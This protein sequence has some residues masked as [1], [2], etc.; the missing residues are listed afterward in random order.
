MYNVTFLFY[1]LGPSISAQNDRKTQLYGLRV[2]SKFIS[3]TVFEKSPKNVFLPPPNG[4]HWVSGGSGL[5]ELN[6]NVFEA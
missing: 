1:V 3:R 6:V 2:F 4:G 5:K